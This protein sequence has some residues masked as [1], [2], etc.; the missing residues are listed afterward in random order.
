[1][2]VGVPSPTIRRL[3]SR[4]GYT[5]TAILLVAL[6]VAA[7]A[8][9]APPKLGDFVLRES[10]ANLQARVDAL[11][12]PLAK[13]G[14]QDL[15]AAANRTA[16][17]GGPC[18]SNVFS[19]I[20]AGSSWYCFDRS[21]S[22]A[23]SGRVEWIPQGVTTVADAQA[24]GKW[25]TR[26]AILVSWYDDA[27]DPKKG[28]RISFLDPNTHKYRHVLLVYPY[29]RSDGRPAYEIVGRPSGGIH[30]GGI[31]WYGNYL[32][33]V[34]TRRGIRVFDM[35]YIFDLSKSSN[36]D[37]Y[38]PSFGYR[39]VMP[40]VGA[41]VNAAGPDNHDEGNSCSGTG[42]PK[43][44]YVSLDRSETPDRLITGEYCNSSRDIGRVA[45]WPLDGASGRLAA[46]ASGRVHASEA[47]RLS[48]NQIQGAVSSGGNWYL[49][50]ST[51]RAPDGKW[52]NGQLIV[53]RADASPAGTL[54]TVETRKAGV[55]PEDLSLWPA[56]G[57]L[58]TVTEHAGQR[59]LYGVPR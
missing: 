8:A 31:L 27:V 2:R 33:V 41:W 26:E 45:R 52:R 28:V 38:G 5:A 29:T 25:G 39:Y 59:M 42:A 58:W 40:Q 14:V 37:A 30:A 20:P 24:D 3:V 46:D 48:A 16:K 51:G 36:P 35:R 15:L 34:D 43:F 56:T 44:S 57:L 6:A 49:S 13:S 1:L 10:T 54:A 11:D 50:R 4:R 7:P 22:G 18:K 17:A 9:A 21:D 55:G 23:G 53:A 12:K 47:Y 32:Y 19:D